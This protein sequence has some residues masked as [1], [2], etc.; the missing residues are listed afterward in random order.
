M[1]GGGVGSPPVFADRLF[2]RIVRLNSRQAGIACRRLADA[3]PATLETIAQQLNLTTRVVRYNLPPV[4]SYLR[5]AGLSVMKRRGVG[6]WVDGDADGRRVAFSGTQSTSTASG[7]TE[8]SAN[9][10]RSKTWL[11]SSASWAQQSSLGG[12]TATCPPA[13]RVGGHA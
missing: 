13:P 3:T 12:M 2:V 10:G 4:E 5:E 1:A 6:I 7:T 9:S 11:R 8:R